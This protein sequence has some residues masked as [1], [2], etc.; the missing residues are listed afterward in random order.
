MT[1]I[2]LIW[3]LIP[4]IFFMLGLTVKN[5][6][7]FTLFDNIYLFLAFIP[8]YFNFQIM[9]DLSNPNFDEGPGGMFLIVGWAVILLYLILYVI[10]S[11][12]INIS[13]KNLAT[14]NKDHIKIRHMLTLVIFFG[15]A[16]ELIIPISPIITLIVYIFASNR[17]YFKD[18]WFDREEITEKTVE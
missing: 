13:N 15:F 16:L 5:R 1:N 18:I 11:N 17:L 7:L 10:Q 4:V 8:A 14:K 3:L 2:I 9:Q 6:K 12:M